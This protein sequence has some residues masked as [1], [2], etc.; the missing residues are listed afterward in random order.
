MWK[1]LIDILKPGEFDALALRSL[2][3]DET[4]AHNAVSPDKM[5]PADMGYIRNHEDYADLFPAGAWRGENVIKVGPDRYWGFPLGVLSESRW[6]QELGAAYNTAARARRLPTR[7]EQVPGFDHDA[8]FFKIP[9]IA[10]KVF[11]HRNK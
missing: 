10:M 9:S 7:S 6:K 5:F 3:P 1:G 2:S 11:E 8:Q 4:F